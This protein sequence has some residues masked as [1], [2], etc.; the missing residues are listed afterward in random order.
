MPII[1]GI[2]TFRE[3]GEGL[4]GDGSMATITSLTVARS[5]FVF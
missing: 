5:L 3:I 2:E 1:A 4:R